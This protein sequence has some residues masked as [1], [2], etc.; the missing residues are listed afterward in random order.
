MDGAGNVTLKGSVMLTSR[1]LVR[2]VFPTVPEDIASG[3]WRIDVGNNEFAFSRQ[4]EA[5][6]KLNL[7][8]VAQDMLEFKQRPWMPKFKDEADEALHEHETRR[9][10]D[11][12]QQILIGT[13][14]RDLLLRRFQVD[15]QPP[16]V[17][18]RGVSKSLTEDTISSETVEM[19]P[20]DVEA[21]ASPSP[22]IDASPRGLLTRNKVIDSWTRRYR[23]PEGQDPVVVEG[24]PEV[25]LNPSQLRAI[26]M[27][28]SERLSLV[29]GVSDNAR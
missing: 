9:R 25:P 15:Y 2:V 8:P 11:K 13:G 6:A 4:R 20:T 5:L 21:T 17:V 12:E 28:L 18:A 3:L 26:A 23:T 16:D 24:D 14:L 19:K 22:H 29:Q 1:G 27:M 7:D 10:P